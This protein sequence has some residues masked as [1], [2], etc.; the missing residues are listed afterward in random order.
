M[1]YILVFQIVGIH[2]VIKPMETCKSL[3]RTAIKSLL[4]STTLSHI[5]KLSANQK[6]LKASQVM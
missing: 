4:F 6:N 5:H 2:I 1:W 3:G